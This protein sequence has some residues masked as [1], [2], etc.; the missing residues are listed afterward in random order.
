MDFVIPDDLL[1]RRDK[2]IDPYCRSY[3]AILAACRA[4]GNNG[5]GPSPDYL[6]AVSNFRLAVEELE[7]AEEAIR[8][9]P[10]LEYVRLKRENEKKKALA[11][12][13][14]KREST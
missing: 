1:D 6:E 14:D 2:C 10:Q 13:E 9:F 12:K 5:A 11:Q 4:S 8:R 3:E 7:V